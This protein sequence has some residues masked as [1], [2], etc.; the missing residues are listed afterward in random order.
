MTLAKA[1]RRSCIRLAEPCA[2]AWI[3]RMIAGLGQAA[4]A[5]GGRARGKVDGGFRAPE[6]EAA[7]GLRL[8]AIIRQTYPSSARPFERRRSRPRARRATA[9]RYG[10]TPRRANYTIAVV[11]ALLNFGIKHGLR[12]P[13]SNP[14]RGIKLYRERVARALSE[15]GRNSAAA[16]AIAR[17]EQEGKSRSLRGGRIAIGAVHWCSLRR[18][19]GH[20][21]G[22]Y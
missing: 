11:R 16:E 12:P 21:M 4:A 18:D 3:P 8:R 20:S 9:C 14:A 13:A 10:R 5:Y 22:V 2:A 6:A 17:I 19:H 7:H 15:R 1:R